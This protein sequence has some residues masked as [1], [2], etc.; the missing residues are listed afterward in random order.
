MEFLGE[1]R[2]S[3][4]CAGDAYNESS[5][6][7]MSLDPCGG[8]ARSGAG[9]G[10]IFWSDPSTCPSGYSGY[11]SFY[12]TD[13]GLTTSGVEDEWYENDPEPLCTRQSVQTIAT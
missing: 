10:T 4:E 7:D 3:G 5:Q 1:G 6:A 9:W 8:S 12:W 11:F 13:G 2:W